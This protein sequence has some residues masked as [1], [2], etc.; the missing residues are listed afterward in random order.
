MEAGCSRNEVMGC[1]GH[2]L[3]S[4]HVLMTGESL[5]ES[6]RNWER[7]HRRLKISH[8]QSALVY[9]LYKSLESFVLTAASFTEII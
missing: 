8:L 7:A 6:V 1:G 4:D 2:A 3:G 5:Q 9:S